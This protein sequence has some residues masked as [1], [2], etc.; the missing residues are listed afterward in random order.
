MQID[1]YL[2]KQTVNNSF[3]VAFFMRTCHVTLMKTIAYVTVTLNKNIINER[4]ELFDCFPQKYKG[5]AAF[6]DIITGR[7]QWVWM[8]IS[9]YNRLLRLA[10]LLDIMCGLSCLHYIQ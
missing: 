4:H 3:L 5:V 8:T 9:N 7:K 2:D 10:A 6:G 1:I